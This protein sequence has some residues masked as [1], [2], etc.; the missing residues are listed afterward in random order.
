MRPVDEEIE[1]YNDQLDVIGLPIMTRSQLSVFN[2]RTNEK[3][4][5]GIKGLIYDVLANAKSYGPEKSYNA[6]AGKESTRL[7]ALNK[8][9]DDGINNTWYIDD[10]SEKQLASL[11]KWIEFFHKRYRIIGVIGDRED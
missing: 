3:I 7:L 5:V 6:L 4:Y 9:K 10:L 8:L 1:Q 2:G 11:D